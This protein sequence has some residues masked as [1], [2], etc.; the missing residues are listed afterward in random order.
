MGVEPF[1]IASTVN[2]AIGQRLVRMVCK[3]CKIKKRITD[4]EYKHLSEV[5]PAKVLGKHRDFFQ[6][7][8]CASCGDTG[9]ASRISIYEILEVDDD[10]R[11][12]I[13]ERKNGSDIK[14]IAIAK[15]MTTLLED[16][17]RKALDG[18]TTIEEILRVVQE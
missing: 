12:A 18:L 14:R 4:A 13:M 17:F 1:L 11:Q 5:I 2:I 15:G 7:K 16:G 10:V 6:G 8:G 3:D 9:Y